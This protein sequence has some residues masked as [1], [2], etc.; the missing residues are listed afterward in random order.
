MKVFKNILKGIGVFFSVIVAIVIFAVS[1]ATICLWTVS[2][3]LS[4][5]MIRGIITSITISTGNNNG[6]SSEAA[7]SVG[8][9]DGSALLVPLEADSSIPSLDDLLESPEIKEI[10]DGLRDQGVDVDA[11]ITVVKDDVIGVIVSDYA[12]GLYEFM[13]TGSTEITV[14]AEY[15]NGILEDVVPKIEEILG[16]E[17]PDDIMGEIENIT[18]ELASQLPTYEATKELI[19]SSLEENGVENPDAIISTAFSVLF[20]TIGKLAPIVILLSLFLLIA[21]LRFSPFRWMCWSGV[22]MLVSGLIFLVAS[23]AGGFAIAF[24]PAV[25]GIDV[26]LIAS[27]ILGSMTKV[28]LIFVITAIVF[29]V[30]Y[31][32]LC[33]VV[34]KMKRKKAEKKAAEAAIAEAP[35]AAEV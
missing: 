8:L 16:Q 28:S 33:S 13:A 3:A 24:I 34:R 19:Y 9:K 10:V 18:G 15:L 25:E 29:I 6:G 31:A 11:L 5:D 21:L 14:D 27:L 1:T 32:V 2:D 30:V 12:E 17:I 23:L 26:A 4:P 35:V 7:A 22:P 20:G